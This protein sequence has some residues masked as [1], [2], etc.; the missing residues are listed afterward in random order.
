M[1]TLETI[2]NSNYISEPELKEEMTQIHR[3]TVKENQ[4]SKNIIKTL[5]AIGVHSALLNYG[6]TIQKALRSLL[7]LLYHSFPKVW[8][9]TS[10][11]LYNYLLSL[12][13][14]EE[15]FS[16]EEEYDDAIVILS[17]TDWSKMLKDL[18]E[19]TQERL[20]VLFKEELKTNAKD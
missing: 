7:F 15:K 11:K 14:Y 2:I 3:F 9:T 4:G 5:S 17:E 6:P 16:S 19:E 1:K 13:S 18:K 12:E 10:E 8:Q 20:F